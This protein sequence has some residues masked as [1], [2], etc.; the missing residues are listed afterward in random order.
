MNN[1]PA[2]IGKK[3]LVLGLGESGFQSALA[4][5]RLGFSVFAT[6]KSE[7]QVLREKVKSLQLQ[8]IEAECGQHSF[9]RVQ[10][11]DWIL[12]SPGIP[13]QSDIYQAVLKSK[14]PIYSEIEE[15]TQIFADF[16]K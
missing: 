15:A 10:A 16:I 11:A 4:L 5:K 1:I 12:I 3:V 13:P 6:D 2:G 7:N 8:E 9:D 14:K